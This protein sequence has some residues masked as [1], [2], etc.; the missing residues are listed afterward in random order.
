MGLCGEWGGGGA[1]KL[2][3]LA[4]NLHYIYLF[5]FDHNV[6]RRMLR[7]YDASL[8]YGLLICAMFARFLSPVSFLVSFRSVYGETKLVSYTVIIYVVGYGMELICV[9]YY[10]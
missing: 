3:L 6:T 8:G 2:I 1:I 7:D 4:P 10:T 9:L 5:F